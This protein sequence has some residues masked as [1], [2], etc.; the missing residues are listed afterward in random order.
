MLA[1]ARRR[2][3]RAGWTNVVLVQADAAE[4]DVED[5][6]ARTP[7]SRGI[8]AVVSTYAL[9]VIPGWQQAWSLAEAT[10]APGARFAI[11]DLGLPTGRGALLAP[12]A[13]LACA[14]G[15]SDP[16][17]NPG[18]YVAARGSEVT[19]RRLLGGHVLV[20]VGRLARPTAG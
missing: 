19:H 14:A 17:R 11:V 1:A 18:A 8:D 4:L 16:H 5:V 2:A 20:D 7:G 15:G 12:L 3:E 9:S 10:A 6:L 13:R